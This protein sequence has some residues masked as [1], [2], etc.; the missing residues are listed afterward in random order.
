MRC[1]RVVFGNNGHRYCYDAGR[2]GRAQVAATVDSESGMQRLYTTWNVARF[3]VRR[4][5]ILVWHTC[6][7][8]FVT[9]TKHSDYLSYD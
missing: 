4:H 6:H 7:P 8:A 1:L 3:Q 2:G 9:T 5:I